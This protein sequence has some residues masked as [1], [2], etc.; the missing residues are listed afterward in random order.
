MELSF[1]TLFI[2]LSVLLILADF[3]FCYLAYQKSEERARYLGLTAFGAG[4]VTLSY[5]ISVLSTSYLLMSV[6]TSIYFMCIDWMLISLIFFVYRFTRMHMEQWAKVTRNLLRVLGTADSLVMIINI[7]SEIAVGYV[8]HPAGDLAP[9]GYQIKPLY[10]AHLIFTYVLVALILFILI[11]KTVQTPRQYRNQYLMLVLA[12]ALVVVVNAL[13]LFPETSSPLTQLD[14]SLFGYSLGLWLL[15]WATFSYRQNEMMKSLSMTVFQNVDQGIV[16]FDHSHELIMHNKRLERLLPAIRFDQEIRED[17]FLEKCSIPAEDHPEDHYSVQCDQ[18][19]EGIQALRCDYRRL[20]DRADRVIGSLYVFTDMTDNSDLLTG[21]QRWESFKRYAMRE[22]G[23][24]H[25]PAAVAVF[26]AIGLGETNRSLGQEAGDQ[27]IRG[28]AKAMRQTM[29]KGTCFIRGHE[30]LL[31]AVCENSTEQDIRNQAEAIVSACADGAVYALSS[32]TE[33]RDERRNIITA[34]ETAEKTLQMKKLMDPKS[35]RS[36]SL[37]S[38]VRALEEADS[39]T[40]AHVVRTQKMGEA[41]GKRI[42]LNDEQGTSLRLLCL[43][44]DIGKIGIPLEILN[45]P[46]RLTAPEWEVLKTH[47]EKGYLI[48]MSSEDLQP[49]APMIRY[50]HERWDGMGYPERLS[51]ENI[52]LLSRIINV[53]D[54][55]D[56]MV[57]NRSYRKARTPEEAQKEIRA[58]AGSQFDPRLAAEFLQMLEANPEIAVGEKTGG[59]EVRTFIEK[60]DLLEEQSGNTIRLPYSRYMLDLDDTII[61]VDDQFETITG[62]DRR[63]VVGRKVQVDLI[64][65]EDRAQY[66]MQVN[67]SFVRGD[68]AFLKHVLLRKDGEKIPVLCHGKRFYDSA[69]KAF[70][71]EIHIVRCK[72]AE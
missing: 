61:E 53:V 52:P 5:L 33:E 8:K 39:D 56:A 54:S 45:K 35:S 26:D 43:L 50:H 14:W 44:H 37:T 18:P 70:R 41:L 9:Y 3:R 46:G 22:P 13:F 60:C 30:A 59:E 69:E 31:I 68:I 67:Q 25:H 66:M 16:L 29:A 27:R 65:A 21:F 36:H 15:F 58:C 7:F 12:I 51:G 2:V 55:Y 10:V 28:L 4:V 64:P 32:T 1:M 38:L 17:A 6:S 63:D 23:R 71:S 48:A 24:F 11:R 40:E 47:A 57:N 20:R 62:Y 42:G 72:D 49:I 19:G 34:I